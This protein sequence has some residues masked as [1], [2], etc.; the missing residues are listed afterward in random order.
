MAVPTR[1]RGRKPIKSQGAGT[2][3]KSRTSERSEYEKR[4]LDRAVYEARRSVLENIRYLVAIR[5]GRIPGVTNQDRLRAIE[6]LLDRA[7]LPKLTQQEIHTDAEPV[8]LFDFRL[9]P[10]DNLT[11]EEVSAPE[12]S[13]PPVDMRE[14]AVPDESRNIM[15]E[16]RPE[17]A[18]GE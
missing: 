8:K 12:P 16:D 14:P 1:K 9:D 10:E 18:G 6:N 7:G 13:T 4:L 15:D 2:E 17:P 3:A 5:D 11:V